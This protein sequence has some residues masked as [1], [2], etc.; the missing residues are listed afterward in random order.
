MRP[1]GFWLDKMDKHAKKKL[2]YTVGQD[3]EFLNKHGLSRKQIE[4]QTAIDSEGNDEYL[5]TVFL[6][7]EDGVERKSIIYV[8]SE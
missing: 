2:L 8:M 1:M 3:K 4:K 7:D 5:L 6:N